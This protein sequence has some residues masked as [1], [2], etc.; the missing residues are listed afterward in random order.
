MYNKFSYLLIV[1][2]IIVNILN[3]TITVSDQLTLP[4][5]KVS[6]C[7]TQGTFAKAGFAVKRI[8]YTSQ[9][10][11]YIYVSMVSTSTFN[12]SMELYVIAPHNDISLYITEARYYYQ[13]NNKNDPYINV[14]K[15][16]LVAA[17]DALSSKYGYIPLCS[18]VEKIIG[19][20]KSK[21]IY[22]SSYMDN[23]VI[24]YIVDIGINC[25]SSYRG[26]GGL[27]L[28]YGFAIPLNAPE[29][30]GYGWYKYMVFFTVNQAQCIICGS[31][32]NVFEYYIEQGT[33]VGT[34]IPSTLSNGKCWLNYVGQGCNSSGGG[35][36][37]GSCSEQ[38]F[39]CTK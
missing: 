12:P 7:A 19:T 23:G 15:N 35:A 4:R 9:S 26:M 25:K 37:S 22:V 18:V 20:G 14:I 30:Y 31:Q 17:C 3:N 34:S 10:E 38:P 6:K 11:V 29:T 21:S 39:A 13:S 5:Y 8:I 32:V 27:Y 24:R 33:Y 36:G 28:V 2:L 16:L 1:S